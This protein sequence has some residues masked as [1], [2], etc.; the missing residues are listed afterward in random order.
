MRPQTMIFSPVRYIGNA[1]ATFTHYDDYGTPST[2]TVNPGDPLVQRRFSLA[3]LPWI[4]HAGPAVLS[5]GSTVTQYFT[6]HVWAAIY[7]NSAGNYYRPIFLLWLRINYALFGTNAWGWHLTSVAC[8]VTATWL[9]FQLVRQL[10]GNRALAFAA[11]M[12]FAVHPAH[13]ENVAWISGVTDPL[14]ACFVLGSFS[15]FLSFQRR[16]G[17]WR[18]ALS[19]AFFGLGLFTKETAVVL[20]WLVLAYLLFAER[21]ERSPQSPSV[22]SPMSRSWEALGGLLVVASIY[23]GARFHALRGRGRTLRP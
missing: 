16:G 2:Y 14:M 23:F 19:L 11:A 15:F 1:P 9:V 22:P 12:I 5:S 13:V 7:P 6:A 18:A 17:V 20:P 21:G 10:A 8:H 3:K 4:T